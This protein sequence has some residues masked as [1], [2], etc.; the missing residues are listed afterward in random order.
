MIT[1][2][3]ATGKVGGKIAGILVKNGEPVRLVGRSVERLRPLVGKH[4]TAFAGDIKDTAFLV[5]A[6]TNAD[7]VFTLIPP[8]PRTGD[9]MEHA[10]KAGES[11]ARALEIAKVGYVVN[12]SS[13]G[14]ELGTGT[15]PIKGLHLNEQ[16]LNSVKGLN[17]LHLRAAYFMENLLGNIDMIKAQGMTGSAVRGDLAMPMIAT[18][19]IAAVA[20]ERLAKRDFIGSTVRYL[21]GQRDL[22]M[23]EASA[24]IGGKIGKSGLPYVRFPYDDAEKAMVGMGLSA[25]MSKNYIEMSR[26]FNDGVI[27]RETRTA[28]KTTPTSFEAFCDEVFV[29][30]YTLK[31]AA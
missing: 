4:A 19:D 27:K 7:A 5:K 24:I 29:P 25:E 16:R 10:G 12:L 13:I 1:I 14:A 15:G 8:D 11:I 6:F 22:T 21:L 26:A 30:L 18:R 31:K 9:F 23:T 2:L 17:V 28:G 20:A 3:G